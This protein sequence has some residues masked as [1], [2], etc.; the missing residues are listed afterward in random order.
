[1]SP[2]DDPTF[3]PSDSPAVK[4]TAAPTNKSPTY[5]PT[6]LIPTI[7]PSVESAFSDVVV[8][9]SV[10]AVG[11]SSSYFLTGVAGDGQSY[12]PDMPTVLQIQTGGPNVWLVE[13]NNRKVIVKEV[14]N[15]QSNLVA[16]IGAGRSKTLTLPW[17]DLMIMV[18]EINTSALHAN[19][20]ITFGPL[21]TLMEPTPSPTLER[22]L[23]PIPFLTYVV[24][25]HSI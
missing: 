3:S 20:E 11:T 25:L 12:Q 17:T 8:F 19:V 24:S 22:T 9:D 1:V 7:S 21:L 18:H 10:T 13:F 5:E 15:G 23:E 16:R 2:T 4:R 14:M 6:N